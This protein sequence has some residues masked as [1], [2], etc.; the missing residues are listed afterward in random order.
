MS[1]YKN[2]K[3]FNAS[4]EKVKA[5]FLQALTS[6]KTLKGKS[7]GANGFSIKSKAAYNFGSWIEKEHYTISG[8]FNQ[9][10]Q[11]TTIG[12]NVRGNETFSIIAIVGV[13]MFLPVIIIPFG[14]QKMENINNSTD[15]VSISIISVL[16]ISGWLFYFL[17]KKKKL[18]EKGEQMFRDFLVSLEN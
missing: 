9:K 1:R 14:I 6:S 8:S 15:L 4:I 17:Y 5:N 16:L 18:R 2:E 3:T 10:A 12:Y 13:L 7:V 11:G